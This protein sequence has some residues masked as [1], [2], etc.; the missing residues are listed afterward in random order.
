MKLIIINAVSMALAIGAIYLAVNGVNGVNGW[1]WFLFG[2]FC[3]FCYPK[4]IK[5]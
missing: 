5:G 4:N 3:T 2:S 1:G